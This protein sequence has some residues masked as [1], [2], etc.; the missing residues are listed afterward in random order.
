MP[1]LHVILDC[2]GENIKLQQL[3][4]WYRNSIPKTPI[5]QKLGL[6]I[7]P[8]I[9]PYWFRDM[10]IEYEQ[11]GPYSTAIAE[12]YQEMLE[13][14]RIEIFND[15]LIIKPTSFE[16]RSLLPAYIELLIRSIISSTMSPILPQFD[17]IELFSI[18]SVEHTRLLNEN[19]YLR[20][21]FVLPNNQ[22]KNILCYRILNRM[23]EI[24]H[25]L[26][27]IHDRGQNYVKKFI[28]ELVEEFYSILQRL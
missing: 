3:T 7:I 28:N 23:E 24:P 22:L 20:R 26:A 13:T 1:I 8:L 19:G 5:I 11:F 4:N 16:E 12:S 15:E 18:I 27:F 2:A 21:M 10:E 6:I 9:F 17:L 25:L 14:G